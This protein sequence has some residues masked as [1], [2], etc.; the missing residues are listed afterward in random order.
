[1]AGI[2]NYKNSVQALSDYKL[3]YHQRLCELIN[4]Q[5]QLA[6]PI[7]EEIMKKDLEKII[8]QLQKLTGGI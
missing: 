6:H 4:A 8:K 1:V 3:I 7:L 2:R 5:R